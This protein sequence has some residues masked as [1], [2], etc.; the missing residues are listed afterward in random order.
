MKNGTLKRLSVLSCLFVLLSA[1]CFPTAAEEVKT[2]TSGVHV[3]TQ[4]G[5]DGKTYM[6]QVKDPGPQITIDEI[7]VTGTQDRIFN[8]EKIGISNWYVLFEGYLSEINTDDKCIYINYGGT[9]NNL[10]D[11]STLKNM[12]FKILNPNGDEIFYWSSDIPNT[13]KVPYSD[14]SFVKEMYI[15][16]GDQKVK[17]TVA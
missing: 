12:G 7:K 3:E 4:V 14:I 17:M 1:F 10:E 6:V 13:I 9:L 11:V 5:K 8:G 15:T 16:Y 2:S